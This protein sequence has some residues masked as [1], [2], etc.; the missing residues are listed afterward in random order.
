MDNLLEDVSKYKNVD[1][2]Y[3]AVRPTMDKGPYTSKVMTPTN[4]DRDRLVDMWSENPMA[5]D[6]NELAALR[7]PF[8]E[9]LWRTTKNF[10]N[11]AGTTFLDGTIGNVVGLANVISGGDNGK[12]EFNDFIDN[13]FSN[14]LQE[15]VEDKR[16]D[17]ILYR[18]KEEQENKWYQNMDTS[19]FWFGQLEN[20]GFMVGAL[21]AG[22]L[23]GTVGANLLGLTNLGKYSKVVNALSKI[24]SA[25]DDVL[26]ATA[27]KA[28]TGLEANPMRT[29]EIIDDII[30]MAEKV[31]FRTSANQVISSTIGAMGEARIEAITNGKDFKESQIAK[32][33]ETY[34]DDIPQE[35]LDAI[36]EQTKAYQNTVFG[37]NTAVLSLSNYVQFK[38][39]FTGGVK[40]NDK[41]LTDLITKSSTKEGLEFSMRKL[42]NVEKIIKYIALGAK[43]PLSEMTEEQLQFAI[44]EGGKDYYDLENNE[45]GKGVI[46]NILG[47]AFKG[48]E[49][50]YGSAEGWEN[51][52]GGF[53]M[54]GLGLPSVKKTDGK[55]GVTMGGAS[56]NDIRDYNR[57]RKS[58]E[59]A[60]AK[61]NEYATN[62]SFRKLYD[63]MVVDSALDKTKEE[64]DKRGY[65]AV[66]RTVE[67]TQLANMVSAF[68]DIGQLDV[69]KDKVKNMQDIINPISTKA[70][71]TK[72]FKELSNKVAGIEQELQQLQVT[73]TNTDPADTETINS[74]TN[75]I[76]ELQEIKVPLATKLADA[77][78][79]KEF[80]A[81]NL[82][83][84]QSS[85]AEIGKAAA[86]LRKLFAYE[87][88]EEVDGQSVKIPKDPFNDLSDSQLIEKLRHKTDKQLERIDKLEKLHQAVNTRF[89]NFSEDSRKSLYLNA[90]QQ[91]DLL[92]R[93]GKLLNELREV[94]TKNRPAYKVQKNRIA[95]VNSF[96][97]KAK[98]HSTRRKLATSGQQNIDGDTVRSPLRGEGISTTPVAASAM[99][100]EEKALL[101][102]ANTLI[103]NLHFRSGK[104]SDNL[105]TAIEELETNIA[106]LGDNLVDKEGNFEEE[107]S[108]QSATDVVE[109]NK[110]LQDPEKLKAFNR[111]LAQAIAKQPVDKQQ[112]MANKARDLATI[113]SYRQVIVG[114][115]YQMVTGQ[116]LLENERSDKTKAAIRKRK[117]KD[118]ER[119]AL[120]K[121]VYELYKSLTTY[122]VDDDYN[123]PQEG[124]TTN[125]K[126]TTISISNFVPGPRPLNDPTPDTI[127]ASVES[128]TN[129][130]RIRPTKFVSGTVNL[131]TEDGYERKLEF[132]EDDLTHLYDTKS[133]ESVSAIAFV[134][135]VKKNE[136]EKGIPFYVDYTTED[137]VHRVS[138]EGKTKNVK[139]KNIYHVSYSR[140][141]EA[142]ELHRTEA[143]A[144]EYE[145]R[146]NSLEALV[147]EQ[148]EAIRGIQDSALGKLQERIDVLQKDHDELKKQLDERT[149]SNKFN[150]K[151]AKDKTYR[152]GQKLLEV[153]VDLEELK[154]QKEQRLESVREVETSMYDTLS[155][156][157]KN[158]KEALYARE[159]FESLVREGNQFND[160]KYI[161][162]L[163]KT[164]EKYNKEVMVFEGLEENTEDLLEV[165]K[166]VILKLEE[167]LVEIRKKISDIKSTFSSLLDGLTAN[168]PPHLLPTIDSSDLR[169]Y[170]IHNRDILDEATVKNIETILD[171]AYDYFSEK[172][173]LEYYA[174]A[175]TNKLVFS[176]E[177]TDRQTKLSKTFSFKAQLAKFKEEHRKLKEKQEA[178]EQALEN[179]KSVFAKDNTI[180]TIDFDDVELEDNIHN[181]IPV[182]LFGWALS[183]GMDGDGNWSENLKNG[184]SNDTQN[185]VAAERRYFRWLENIGINAKVSNYKFMTVTTKDPVYGIGGTNS[186]YVD[187]KN[188]KNHNDDDIRLVLVEKQQDGSYA[189][190]EYLGGVVFSKL[191]TIGKHFTNGTSRYSFY[192]KELTE[193]EQKNILESAI[194][195]HSDFRD[196]IKEN[197]EKNVYLPILSFNPG[198]PI[199]DAPKKSVVGT[200]IDSIEDID[201]MNILVSVG[202][203]ADAKSKDGKAVIP[204]GKGGLRYP[205]GNVL[206]RLGNRL[207]GKYVSAIT[208]KL[209]ENEA[210]TTY[211]LIKTYLTELKGSTKEATQLEK[212][213]TYKD[214][215]TYIKNLVHLSNSS[216]IPFDIKGDVVV[217]NGKAVKLKNLESYKEEILEVLM[218]KP[219]NINNHTLAKMNDSN[220]NDYSEYVSIAWN[221]SRFVET[222]WK[223]YKHYLVSPVNP[224]GS[225]RNIEADVPLSAYIRMAQKGATDEQILNGETRRFQQGYAHFSYEATK[226]DTTLS[227]DAEKKFG[228]KPVAANTGVTSKIILTS[229]RDSSKGI[230]IDIENKKITIIKY[231][232]KIKDADGND[233]S[234]AELEKRLEKVFE[235]E[236]W[237][238]PDEVTE[239][240]INI[241]NGQVFNGATTDSFIVTKEQIQKEPEASSLEGFMGT[242]AEKS[243]TIP[244]AGNEPPLNIDPNKVFNLFR[245]HTVDTGVRDL[246][247]AESWLRDTLGI[248]TNNEEQYKRNEGLIDGIADGSLL[249]KGTIV[250]SNLG[251]AGTEFH[252]GFHYVSQFLT[253]KQEREE[254]YNEWRTRNNKPNATELEAE[255]GLAEGFREYMLG[256]KPETKK[257]KTIFDKIV[258]AIKAAFFLNS[259]SKIEAFYEKIKKGEFKNKQKLVA[260]MNFARLNNTLSKQDTAIN[261]HFFITKVLFDSS[262]KAL[263]TF[264]TDTLNKSEVAELYTKAIREMLKAYGQLDSFDTLAQEQKDAV[265]DKLFKLHSNYIKG[266]GVTTEFKDEETTDEELASEETDVSQGVN[267][268][269][270]ESRYVGNESFKEAYLTSQKSKAAK[271]IKLL[272]AGLSITENYNSL[273]NK[274]Q[275]KLANAQSYDEMKALLRD[276]S[277]DAFVR[278]ANRLD[279]LESR[280]LSGKDYYSAQLIV[281][282]FN[283]FDKTKLDFIN[284][285][286]NRDGTIKFNNTNTTRREEQVKQKWAT[287]ILAYAN[288][289]IKRNEE[290]VKLSAEGKA[291]PNGTVETDVAFLEAIGMKFANSQIVIDYLRQENKEATNIYNSISKF[292]DNLKNG[293]QN[294]SEIVNKQTTDLSGRLK[295]LVELEVYLNDDNTENQ[296]ITARGEVI[297]T[298]TLHNYLTKLMSSLGTKVVPKYLK[299]DKYAEDS[300][301]LKRSLEGNAPTIKVLNG[302]NKQAEA[303]EDT[304][305]L[306]FT[307]YLTSELNHTL[308]KRYTLLITGDKKTPW[309][310]Q[311]KKHFIDVEGGIA[312]DKMITDC[313]NQMYA[314][315]KTEVAV[316]KE[317]RHKKDIIVQGEQI[318]SDLVIF[319]DI[320]DN[321]GLA[322]SKLDT[323]TSAKR[324]LKEFITREIKKNKELFKN[325]KVI[326]DNTTKIEEYTVK[327]IIGKNKASTQEDVNSLVTAFT[328]NF[329]VSA[330][331]QTKVIF[332]NPAYYTT[333]YDTKGNA[334]YGPSFI[335]MFK[336]YAGAVATT[337]P[338]MINDFINAYMDENMPRND[339]RSGEDRTNL[340]VITFE[341]IK[342][343]RQELSTLPDSGLG[344][345]SSID[346]TDSFGIVLDDPYRDLLFRSDSWNEDMNNAWLKE[347]KGIESEDVLPSIKP[348]IYGTSSNEALK[349]FYVKFALLR[350]SPTLINA[351]TNDA[352]EYPALNKLLKVMKESQSDMAVFKS[353]NKI[354][355]KVNKETKKGQPLY[356][357]AGDI[358]KID[359]GLTTTISMNYI[360][361][362]V[363]NAPKIPQTTSKGTQETAII[364]TDIAEDGVIPE[365]NI[366][367][368]GKTA[369]IAATIEELFSRQNELTEEYRKEITE[370]LKLSN[371][372][373]GW[374]F[375]DGGKSLVNLLKQEANSRGNLPDSQVNALVNEIEGLA[376]NKPVYLDL[377]VNSDKLEN[378]LFALIENRVVNQTRNGKSL[379]QFPDTGT[380]IGVREVVGGKYKSKGLKFY[381]DLKTMEVYLPWYLEG[382][383]SKNQKIS[384]IDAD[385]LEMYG[386]RIPTEQLNSLESIVVK[387]FLPKSYGNTCIVPAGITTKVGSDFDFD[388]INIYFPNFT[389]IEHPLTDRKDFII[390]EEYKEVPVKYRQ[391]LSNLSND[392]FQ[393]LLTDLNQYSLVSDRGF[394]GRLKDSDYFKSL[395]KDKQDMLSSLKS[396]LIYF[397]QRRKEEGHLPRVEYKYITP[398]EENLNN[399]ELRTKALQNRILELTLGLLKYREA[400]DKL[401]PN[402]ISK[403]DKLSLSIEEKLKQYYGDS[404]QSTDYSFGSLLSYSTI[405]NLKTKF[406]YGKDL[407]GIFALHNKNHP[408]AQLVGLRM[409]NYFFNEKGEKVPFNVRFKGISSANGSYSLGKRLSNDGSKISMT[410]GQSVSLAVDVIK[411]PEVMERFNLNKQTADVFCLLVR[412]G[413]PTDTALYFIAQ[414]IV[415]EYV[416]MLAI[417]GS[418]AVFGGMKKQDIEKALREKFDTG[419]KTSVNFDLNSLGEFTKGYQLQIFDDFLMYKEAAFKLS[420]MQSNFAFDTRGFSSI[421]DIKSINKFSAKIKAENTF[422]GLDRLENLTFIKEFKRTYELTASYFD[423]L[424]LTESNPVLKVNLKKMIDRLSLAIPNEKDRIKAIKTLKN[425]LKVALIVSG[426]QTSSTW[427]AMFEGVNSF[428]KQLARYLANKPNS[429]LSAIASVINKENN[430][431]D[432]VRLYNRKMA[433]LQIEAVAEAI[434]ELLKSK[435]SKELEL[436]MNLIKFSLLQSGFNYSQFS[437]GHIL[438]AME[439]KD[440]FKLLISKVNINQFNFA[441]FEEEFYVNNWN[442]SKIVPYIKLSQ[443]KNGIISLGNRYANRETNVIDDVAN[444]GDYLYPYLKTKIDE[445][446]ILYKKVGVSSQNGVLYV[447][448]PTPKLANIQGKVWGQRDIG[449]NGLITTSNKKEEVIDKKEVESNDRF[450]SD[451]LGKYQS[452]NSNA[453]ALFNTKAGINNIVEYEALLKVQVNRGIPKET[454]ENQLTSCY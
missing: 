98:E 116:Q 24:E 38:N 179:K 61:A 450:I 425:D 188:D 397:N 133:G 189:P 418:M 131:V 182:D 363:E 370:E 41:I 1:N 170:L 21:G 426:S 96:L 142:I 399:P 444:Y 127:P 290:E 445:Q 230:V 180:E 279:V 438:P 431:I 316:S 81:L 396:A 11:L 60:V 201:D 89:A 207:G 361:V 451:L 211:Q 273:F 291:L 55:W 119:E 111:D 447:P 313:V 405:A 422:I 360:G 374:V 163:E 167:E 442:N 348:V 196:G 286:S 349:P 118:L 367:I 388:K 326:T 339:G 195:I 101:A 34:G 267:E 185:P 92:E 164:I 410:L 216:K 209:N 242:S 114:Q 376:T 293:K 402:S 138:E 35:K 85:E 22:V 321:N 174:K 135:Q 282:F 17:N 448:V 268:K 248:D 64:A 218:S 443:I 414:P 306:S 421:E 269:E 68:S 323:E 262:S 226:K 281:S 228:K 377:L 12:S 153:L 56:A 83:A 169:N 298:V 436:G 42:G 231:T 184:I 246:E 368:K 446:Y 145:A 305:K 172:N 66:L 9:K 86:D 122:V 129:K 132:R 202:T 429:P 134:A 412:L 136:E 324:K 97:E 393:S 7:Q 62:S 152:L 91:E 137:G 43:N 59:A 6:Y 104:T 257:E 391:A 31:K 162:R 65:E 88:T 285:I 424:F 297:Y 192:N 148:E 289:Y 423:K 392:E 124:V 69:L 234:I 16:V 256:I 400:R 232:P 224:D 115:Y 194:K 315:F 229:K 95:F 354:G 223:N 203:E 441:Q 415:R 166:E 120:N 67:K 338:L 219:L 371:T 29:E 386:F 432:N 280:A 46:N 319:K 48:L 103:D 379:I 258:N 155:T 356:D 401:A 302:M 411:N 206:F 213:F 350:L 141:D 121:D 10:V 375:T 389:K 355:S 220:T 351:L 341:D 270:L 369:T 249:E 154:A 420:S 304:S 217:F 30:Q 57:S 428:P 150:G 199:K 198:T 193:K 263:F 2:S 407:V 430:G 19:N 149:G 336:R 271:E 394:E 26:K 244:V 32:L 181:A 77:E 13:P 358:A 357:E 334:L 14:A 385:N 452:L 227:S 254:L 381:E 215:K 403:F 295:T 143:A 102:E 245:L 117:D 275:N 344:D 409:K 353:G 278:L 197:P 383:L 272:V 233:V 33:R 413:L 158:L 373:N 79:K 333:K 404:R 247:S 395:G 343:V 208:R 156:L 58:T 255:E 130:D 408:L 435:D 47:S 328:V 259:E 105:D 106:K 303:G 276:S 337:K 312:D 372:S 171:L 236:D 190:V 390:S 25:G 37:L 100:E 237:V 187:P 107:H 18:T 240:L 261:L 49:E 417:E 253:T 317:G 82:T 406:W 309:A 176:R 419:V 296:A 433:P 75:R 380:E 318:L 243:A 366:T 325:N 51:A 235:E 382:V 327:S 314:Y 125:E 144:R 398:N 113:S 112:A 311:M 284:I 178:E 331:E 300:I 294:L 70:D 53:I 159:N 225:A 23:T 28:L 454:I 73:L 251:I 453:R 74:L 140:A 434:D 3:K 84:E 214:V 52:F 4:P 283:V 76:N 110:Y 352:G 177:Y 320:K 173:T 387:G 250:L 340:N 384:Q 109:L 346:E 151:Q 139:R 335:D 301:I 204:T 108:W 362:Q 147:N 54:G 94:A 123:V 205:K 287:E 87:A 345:Y 347:S 241:F 210:E 183:A 80:D 8:S 20:A 222:K 165:S 50:A 186:V 146:V 439:S 212:G 36:D 277:N 322:L 90:V 191:R 308:A 71:V 126:S 359:K 168:I 299:K 99:M 416:E 128:N 329:M 364:V 160:P 239:E 63:Y 437:I 378:I 72:S 252:E 330:I 15:F 288:K 365:G 161:A 221:G 40:L 332:G 307:D 427:P 292:I 200:I 45:E 310:L 274:L 266:L 260:K 175:L 44:S 440:G 93:G 238:V 264:G 5:T 342:A 39:L 27:K 157:K 449:Y 78:T 265:I